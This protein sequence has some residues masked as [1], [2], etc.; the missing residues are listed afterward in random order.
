[1][2]RGRNA[3]IATTFALGLMVLASVAAAQAPPNEQCR[4]E[5]VKNCP[6]LKPGDG[7]YGQCLV[8][9]KSDFSAPCQQ[10]PQAAIARKAD[11]KN[12]PSCLADA[13]KLCPSTKPSLTG[14]TKCLRLH[15]GDLSSECR[16]ELGKRTGK[17]H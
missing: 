11:L 9:H 5:I 14:L 1:M 2:S 16:Q 13:E 17:Y 6:G 12:F 3:Y 15:Q 4:A 8:D 7:K 10:Y